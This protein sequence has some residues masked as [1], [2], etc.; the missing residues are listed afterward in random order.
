MSDKAKSG[1]TEPIIGQ[2]TK[3]R[4]AQLAPVENLSKSKSASDCDLQ[5]AR[6]NLKTFER[7]KRGEGRGSDHLHFIQVLTDVSM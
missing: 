2:K 6:H 3:S 1:K 4:L 5:G 7:E